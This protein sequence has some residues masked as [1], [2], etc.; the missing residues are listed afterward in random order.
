MFEEIRDCKKCNLYCNQLPLIDTKDKAD[1]FFVGLSA[2]IIKEKGDIPLSS[3]TN[4]GMIIKK[5][6]DLLKP[7][8]IYRTNL[9]KCVPL[10]EKDKLRYP[11]KGEINSCINNLICEIN[12]IKPKIVF[13]LG[14]KVT[15]AVENYSNINFDKWD[16][17][18]YKYK[19]L[20]DV[21]YVPIHHPSYIYVYKKKQIEEYVI[22]VK[23]V[24]NLIL[25]T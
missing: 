4:S 2:K 21:Y 16:D 13:L 1:V 3:N 22:A 9:V 23:D 10:D 14:E 8:S 7:I 15:S 24:V 25:N 18:N 20:N 11:A 12:T 17:F 5:I 19:M 6:E